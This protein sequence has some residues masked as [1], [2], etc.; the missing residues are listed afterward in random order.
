ML[1]NYFFTGPNSATGHTSAIFS[2]EITVDLIIKLARPIIQKKKA[3]VAVK[4]NYE[5]EYCD[6]QQAALQNRVWVDCRYER[7]TSFPPG[8]S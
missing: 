2:I 1:S 4:Y 8:L 3:E 5:T 7:P 6:K